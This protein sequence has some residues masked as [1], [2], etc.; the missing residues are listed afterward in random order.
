MIDYEQDYCPD[1]DAAEVVW[2]SE[3]YRVYSIENHGDA[4]NR[5]R[6]ARRSWTYWR[7]QQRCF[8]RMNRAS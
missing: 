3:P 2:D 8:W 1:P 7:W 5:Q 6:R 4:A